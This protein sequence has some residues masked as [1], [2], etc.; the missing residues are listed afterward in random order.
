MKYNELSRLKDLLADSEKYRQY[1]YSDSDWQRFED[2]WMV[3]YPS[4]DDEILA[5]PTLV[6]DEMRLMNSI[7]GGEP[8]IEFT[9]DDV[10]DWAKMKIITAKINHLKNQ[11]GLMVELEDAVQDA[12]TLGTGFILDGFGSQYGVDY[13]VPIIGYD[14]TRLDRRGRR[15]EYHDNISDNLPFS[16]R[17]HPSNIYVPPGTVNTRSAYGFFV[18]YMRHVD[19]VRGDEKLIAKHRDKVKPNVI[20]DYGGDQ[21]KNYYGCMSDMVMLVDWYDL[22]NQRRITFTKDYPYALKDETDQITCRLNRL[23][24]HTLI[25]NRNSRFFWGTSDFHLNESLAKEANDIRTMQMKIRHVQIMKAIYDKTMIEG[26]EDALESFENAAKAIESD[27]V[28]AMVGVETGG[29]GIDQFIKFVTPSQPWDLTQQ[30]D[31]CK[32]DMRELLGMGDNQ[33]GQLS[34]G[35]HT[36]YEAALAESHHDRSLSSRRRAIQQ[37]ITDV[38]YNWS[39]LIYDFCT[40]PE[41]CRTTDAYGN[42]VI[43]DFCGA[44]LRGDYKINVNIEAMRMRNQE[45]RVQE[46]NMVLSQLA[47][48]AQSGKIN[49]DSLIRQWMTRV[50][51]G[52][53]IEAIM[54]GGAMS[55][56]GPSMSFDQ[57]QQRMMQQMNQMPPMPQGISSAMA[58]G[59]NPMAPRPITPPQPG[60]G[61]P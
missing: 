12:G 27:D 6:S 23:P 15:I 37:L 33:R 34:T 40:E 24:L 5:V 3:K 28:M 57:Y 46:A 41:K 10:R 32:K 30:Y 7:F 25:F 31:L 56:A 4:N 17:H 60:G 51:E 48:L 20:G 55:Q 36:R 29:K 19:D 39:Q 45:E 38:A 61:R 43:V 49:I 8:Y 1:L 16:L 42:T 44:D 11:V 13:N 47:P 54:P 14:S 21:D 2:Y 53:D 26:N 9:S 18:Q 22:R 58:M 35:R 50:A 59:R 52:W